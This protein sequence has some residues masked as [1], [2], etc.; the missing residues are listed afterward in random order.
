MKKR[1]FILMV[2]L[3]L[4][5]I[6]LLSSVIATES[7]NVSL[8]GQPLIFDVSPQIINDRTM[9]PFRAIF[10]SLGAEV[11]WDQETRTAIGIKDDITIH[12]PIDSYTAMVNGNSYLLDS[13]ATIIEGR[14][15]VPIRF[16]SE[17]MGLS[18]NWVSSSRTVQ[19]STTGTFPDPITETREFV[20]QG[21]AIGSSLSSTIENLEQPDRIDESIYGFDWYI[22]NNDYGNYIQVGIENNTVVALFSNSQNWT[23][24]SG[25]KVGTTYQSVHN[26][27][28]DSLTKIKKG[29][30]VYHYLDRT[31]DMYLVDDS[32]LRVFYDEHNNNTLTSIL[33]I[34]KD[35]EMNL[36]GYYGPPS[37]ALKVSFEKQSLDLANAIRYRFDK[38]PL[39]WDSEASQTARRH[40]QDM[41]DRTFFDHVNPDNESSVERFQNDSIDYRM[42]AENIALGQFSAI[43]VHEEWMNSKG[44]RDN[45]LLDIERLGVGVYLAPD[46]VPYYTQ[47]F[48]TPY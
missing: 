34:D 48:Y 14:T 46:G 18:V 24:R 11:S 32:Y 33:L 31:Y 43:Y 19:L 7:I 1:K 27:Y 5:S 40:S 44:H 38:D 30:T 3:F 12:L 17:N 9:V 28:G 21:L 2:A 29:N 10:E 4:I 37:E 39:S 22:Y 41:S 16:I 15:L 26:H 45:L 6:T 23:S 42:L 25:L 35:V 13:P 36:L 8:D 47:N 20:L